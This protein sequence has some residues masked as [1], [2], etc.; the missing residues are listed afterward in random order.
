MEQTTIPGGDGGWRTIRCPQCGNEFVWKQS[1]DITKVLRCEN[2]NP[3]TGKP[4]GLKM[5]RA[6]WEYLK[7]REEQRRDKHA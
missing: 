7:S 4:C 5:P 1:N 2:T 6:D 3:D